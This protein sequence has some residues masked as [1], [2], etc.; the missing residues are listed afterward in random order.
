[1]EDFKEM[2]KEEIIKRQGKKKIRV[3]HREM[4][5]FLYC[6]E[7][8]PPKVVYHM[9]DRESAEAILKEKRVRCFNSYGCFFLPKKEY[10][11]VYLKAF[12]ETHHI[13]TTWDL[14]RVDLGQPDDLVLLELHIDEPQEPHRWYNQKF[15][16]PYRSVKDPQDF[17]NKM[18]KLQLVHRGDLRISSGRA[19]PIAPM[20]EYPVICWNIFLCDVGFLPE[21]LRIANHVEE[22]IAWREKLRSAKEKRDE[23]RKLEMTKAC[24]CPIIPRE[25]DPLKDGLRFES[26]FLHKL[27]QPRSS[28]GLRND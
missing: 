11:S 6:R 7:V 17:M 2:K 1:M 27:T 16:I 20:A 13:R 3:T 8:D 12:V 26:S 22:Y 21:K 28:G 10:C 9:T 24:A 19:I 4:L 14:D 18:S 15:N 25:P 5:L 23:E